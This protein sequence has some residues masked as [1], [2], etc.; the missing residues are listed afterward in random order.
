[1]QEKTIL[2]TG[3][4]SGIGNSMVRL[5]RENGM[6][7]VAAG[8]NQERLRTLSSD[9]GG[10]IWTYAADLSELKNVRKLF[11]FCR[12]NKLKLDGIVHCAG[13]TLNCP[14]RVN[15]I[16]ETEQLMR[17]NV[18]ALIEICHFA[19]SGRY[20]SKGASIVALSS[21]A[22]LCGGRGLAAYSAS[23]AAV[24]NLVKSAA[25]ELSPRQIRVNAIAPAMVRTPMYYDTI[26]QIPDI[27]AAVQANQPFGLIEPESIAEIAAFLMSDKAKYITGS[28]LTVSAGNVL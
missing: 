12:E 27:E 9:L 22:S 3:A 2:V 5:F 11:D 25:L 10:Q 16:S 24:N 17:I 13:V 6:A 20:V 28:V 15:D 21:T 18:E 8:R 7:V 26:A 19:S 23:K 14:L 1:M 4:T